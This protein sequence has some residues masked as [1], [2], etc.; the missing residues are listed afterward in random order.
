MQAR[1]IMTTGILAVTPQSSIANAAHLMLEH[2]ISGL[3]VVD[4]KGTL[5][6][7]VTERDLVCRPEISTA[8]RHE[9][10]IQLWLTPDEL[11]EE[12]VQSRGR[13]VGEVM[14]C[15]VVSITPDTP[16]DKIVALMTRDGVKRLPVVQDGKVIG[17][18]SRADLLRSLAARLDS[19]PQAKAADLSA[20]R[21]ILREIRGKRW[22]PRPIINVAVCDSV[23]ELTG[24][25]ASEI[26]RDA[27]RVAAENAPGVIKVIDHLSVVPRTSGSKG[28]A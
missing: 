15:Q 23:V 4:Q 11:A 20:R 10:W 19:L 21:H 3:P 16:L 6:G 14:T 1:D 25:V 17:I 9:K 22:A 26:V 12:Y 2:R 7:I 13:T 5:V 27:V 18:V 24:S 8:P 28:R